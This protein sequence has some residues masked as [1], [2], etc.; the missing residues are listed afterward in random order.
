MP[1]FGVMLAAAD[2]FS[3]EAMKVFRRSKRIDYISETHWPNGCPEGKA[4]PKLGKIK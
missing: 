1:I 2:G 4:S 3:A